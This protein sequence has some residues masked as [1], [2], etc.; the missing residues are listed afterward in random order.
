[1]TDAERITALELSNVELR[2]MLM[3]AEGEIKK[4]NFGKADTPLLRKMRAVLREARTL[5]N[6]DLRN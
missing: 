3:L 4:L 2:A 1:M 5:R 6:S